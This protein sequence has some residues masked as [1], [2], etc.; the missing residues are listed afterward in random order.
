[1]I[2]LQSLLKVRMKRSTTQT[3]PVDCFE[4]VYFPTDSLADSDVV[5]FSII[6]GTISVCMLVT[7]VHY[8]VTHSLIGICI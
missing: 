5:M 8:S 3:L 1:M 4:K 7:T 2:T 6:L